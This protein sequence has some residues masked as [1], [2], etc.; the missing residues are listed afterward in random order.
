VGIV[1]LGVRR[2][3]EFFSRITEGTIRLKGFYRVISQSWI[4]LPCVFRGLCE[5]EIF[6][7]DCQ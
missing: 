5:K 2:D 7:P 3:T 4:Y 6:M 1:S